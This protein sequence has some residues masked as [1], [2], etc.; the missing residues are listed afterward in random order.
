M[1]ALALGFDVSICVDEDIVT[2]TTTTR[3]VDTTDTT[4]TTT[5]TTTYPC[6][7]PDQCVHVLV[8]WSVAETSEVLW[9]IMEDFADTTVAS[10]VS[11]SS[12]CVLAE[13]GYTLVAVDPL[14]R[15]GLFEE[16]GL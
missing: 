12:V 2:T 10:G 15:G 6:L 11:N 14:E 3:V 9:E 5:V 1:T 16:A 13:K 7:D 8:Q 4:T